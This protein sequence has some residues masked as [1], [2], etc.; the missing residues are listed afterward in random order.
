MVRPANPDT[1]EMEFR[2]LLDV[3]VDIIA[4]K[5]HELSIEAR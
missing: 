1:E 2:T 4:D 3:P 5:D